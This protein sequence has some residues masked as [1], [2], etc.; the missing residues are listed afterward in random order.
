MPIENYRQ[1]FDFNEIGGFHI[2]LTA[3]YLKHQVKEYLV[4]ESRVPVKSGGVDH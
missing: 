4:F 3:S 1:L 2:A